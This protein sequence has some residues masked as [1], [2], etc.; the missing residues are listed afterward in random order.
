MGISDKFWGKRSASEVGR[1]HR[2]P[3]T[4]P[5]IFPKFNEFK[6]TG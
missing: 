3:G 2:Q 1:I 4:S 6:R 5:E